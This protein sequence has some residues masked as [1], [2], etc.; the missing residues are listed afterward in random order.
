M[1][2]RAAMTISDRAYKYE[3]QLA[4]AVVSTAEQNQ[5]FDMFCVPKYALL[6]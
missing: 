1:L 6:V 3:S 4:F 2:C 5:I